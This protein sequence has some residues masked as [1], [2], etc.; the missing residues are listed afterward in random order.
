[1]LGTTGVLSVWGAPISSSISVSS[2]FTS[3]TI[4]EGSGKVF[5]GAIGCSRSLSVESISVPKLKSFPS[6]RR[7]SI[8]ILVSSLVAGTSTVSC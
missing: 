3:D 5:L 1:M 6:D 7:A 4:G 2:E 8:A